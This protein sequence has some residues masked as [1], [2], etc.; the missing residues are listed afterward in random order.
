M[1]K[2]TKVAVAAGVI[3]AVVIA[4]FI[5]AAYLI[6]RGMI[7]AGVEK[8]ATNQTQEKILIDKS[9][10]TRMRELDP[11]CAIVLGAGIHDAETPSMMLKDRLDLAIALYK[12]DLVPRLLLTGDNGQKEHNEIHV[13]LKY[14]RDH[15]VPDEDI[16]CDHAG[17]STYESFYRADYIF[18]VK[19]AVVVTQYYHLF[20]ALFLADHFGIEVLGAASDQQQP[21]PY[22]S[23]RNNREILARM[24]DFFMVIWKPKPTYLGDK[25]PINSESGTATHGE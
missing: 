22:Q 4:V 12:E 25:I 19:R 10:K 9:A 5:L 23:S 21:Y 2:R 20:R 11:E 15:G 1:K 7:R 17:F 16:F 14:C 13:M 8:T 3:L 24:K 18:E 6:N